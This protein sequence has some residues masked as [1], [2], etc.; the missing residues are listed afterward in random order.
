VKADCEVKGHQY[1]IDTGRCIK[2]LKAK[3]EQASNENGD[4]NKPKKKKKKKKDDDD[5]DD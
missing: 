5:N 2:S 3:P 1:D 4:A